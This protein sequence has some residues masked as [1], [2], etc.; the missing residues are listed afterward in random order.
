MT[1]T[2]AVLRRLMAGNRRHHRRRR[3][4]YDTVVR[5]GQ[6]I[7]VFQGKTND[8]SR[9]G[10]RIT[11]Y[12]SATGVYRNQ[13]V[14]VDFLLVPK[15]VHQPSQRISVQGFVCRVDEQPEQFVIGVQF[16]HLLSSG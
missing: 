1:G 3:L 14:R 9:G 13:M 11:G 16:E 10:A 4:K 12:P 5:D 7:I 8:L 15:D 2:L 6:G